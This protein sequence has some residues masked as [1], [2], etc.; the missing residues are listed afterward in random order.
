MPNWVTIKEA[1]TH[2]LV[3]SLSVHLLPLF[4]LLEAC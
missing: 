3:A 4:G 1:V 2:F